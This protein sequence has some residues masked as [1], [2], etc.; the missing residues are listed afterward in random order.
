MSQLEEAL[1]ELKTL[2]DVIRWTVSRF[3]E[4]KIFF[5]HG[6]DNAWDEAVSLIVP[7]LHLDYDLPEVSWQARLTHSEIR[8]LLELVVRRIQD[9]IPVPYLTHAAR[10]AGLNFYVDER[11]LIPRSPMAELI[12]KRFAPWLHDDHADRILDMCTGSACIAVACAH[13]LPES[14]VDAVDISKEALAVAKTNIKNHHLEDR[15]KPYQ[16]DL[17][18]PLKRKYQYD[19]I[20]ANPP[21]VDKKDIAHLPPEY[22]HEPSLGLKG[23]NDG[24][25]LV[26][27]ILQ[28]AKDFL[29]PTGILVV[30]VGNSEHTLVEKFSHVPFTWLEFERGDGGVFLLTYQDL[31]NYL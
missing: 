4:A 7:T 15:V 3:N 27:K 5:G 28:S 22:L 9:R 20:I 1:G 8:H 11:V 30:E 6:T 25:D 21:Y 17:F 29:K 19:V 13:Y 12:E 14:V 26:K 23:G 10:F 16:G 24:L 2:N 31:K 18:A